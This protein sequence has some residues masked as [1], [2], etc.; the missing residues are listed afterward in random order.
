MAAVEAW[1]RAWS[2]QRADD[3]L[4]FYSQT[5]EPQG[6]ANRAEWEA[7]R[8]Q[9]IARP[10]RTKV[11]VA[12]IDLRRDNENRAEIEFLQSYDL[13]GFSDTIVKTLKLVREEGGWKIAAEL[14]D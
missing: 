3:Y 8:R 1:A 10:S 5:F 4:S 9:R 6:G 11:R 2:E 13:D 7:E 12:L 14:V